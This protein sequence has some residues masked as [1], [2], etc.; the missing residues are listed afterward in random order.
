M[1]ADEK[2]IM[3]P[4]Q[5][6][7]RGKIQSRGWMD[8]SGKLQWP[9]DEK[10]KAEMARGLFGLEL[11]SN[12]DYWTMLAQDDLYNTFNAPWADEERWKAQAS[13]NL[14]NAPE[15][16]RE[17]VQQT[18]R[19]R[20]MLATLSEDQREVVDELIQKTTRGLLFSFCCTLDQSLGAKL[21]V[22]LNETPS[23]EDTPIQI[24]PGDTLDLHDEQGG[25]LDDFSMVFGVESDSEETGGDGG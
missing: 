25:W 20:E 13:Q 2:D 6:H 10:A 19:C 23:E 15:Y 7:Y 12:V 11:V 21:T 3:A 16:V 22:L 18:I 9:N 4:H 1:H 17:K 24:C 8:E 14:D 5:Q